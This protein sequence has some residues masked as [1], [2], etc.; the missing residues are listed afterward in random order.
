MVSPVWTSD[1]YDG[2]ILFKFLIPGTEVANCIKVLT[3]RNA[4]IQ[5]Q[6]NSRFHP[7]YDWPG[8][9]TL[10]TGSKDQL[11]IWIL[12]RSHSHHTIRFHLTIYF[13]YT[14]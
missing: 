3:I 8:L 5:Q 13:R 12:D 11:S 2:S 6:R 1:T 4:S 14:A 7:F 10:Y 9:Y